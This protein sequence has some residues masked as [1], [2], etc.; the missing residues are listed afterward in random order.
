MPDG[1]REMA[2]LDHWRVTVGEGG[3]D[4]AD[5]W[6]PGH[7]GGGVL[8]GCEQFGGGASVLLPRRRSQVSM[9]ASAPL[10]CREHVGAQVAGGMEGALGSP[11]A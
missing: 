8:V 5:R 3:G 6:P 2:Y 10:R 1:L 7:L 4:I 9:E 11:S